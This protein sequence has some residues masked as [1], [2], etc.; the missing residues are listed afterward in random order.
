MNKSKSGKPSRP[1]NADVVQEEIFISYFTD[2]LC[3]WSWAFEK[4][5][6]QLK[7]TLSD[8]LHVTYHMGGLIPDWKTF[9]DSVN[10][11]AR[12]LQMGPVWMH[13]AEITNVKLNHRLWMSDPPASSYP[14]CIAF[15]CAEL[16]SREAGDLYLSMLREA[17]ML[18]GQN[19]SKTETILSLA[20]NPAMDLVGLD[21]AKFKESLFDGSGLEAFRNDL[22][23]THNHR[24]TRFPGLVIRRKN[25][26]SLLV[27]GYKRIDELLRIIQF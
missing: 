7:E 5:W 8:R 27:S 23:L 26:P 17:A 6:R 24:I 19:I 11:V 3:A 10:D 18:F 4:E 16:Q 12:P 13:I 21:R 1:N 2:P 9:N 22:Q 25:K 15:K 14:A 20:A